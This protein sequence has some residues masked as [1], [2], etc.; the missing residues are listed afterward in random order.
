[1]MPPREDLLAIELHYRLYDEQPRN[2][3]DVIFEDLESLELG[4]TRIPFLS[5]EDLFIVSAHHFFLE[6]DNANLRWL[7]DLYYFA[8]AT[9]NFEALAERAIK[10]WHEP[11]TLLLAL[12]TAQRIFNTP[13]P[14]DVEKQLAF[15]LTL[16]EKREYLK[17]LNS[18]FAQINKSSIFYAIYKSRRQ[19]ARERSILR[20]LFPM[21]AAV[22]NKF[23]I[24]TT[25]KRFWSYRLKYVFFKLKKALNAFFPNA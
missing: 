5:L 7:F 10:T 21:P 18:G 12:K 16:K 24:S 8:D 3:V 23:K 13:L 1:L 17:F 14:A 2:I 19:G 11:F 4:S 9:K 22:S 25:D 6:L 20:Q 15:A